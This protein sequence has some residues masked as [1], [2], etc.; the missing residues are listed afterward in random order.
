[1]EPQ[2]PGRMQ[3][4]RERWNLEFHQVAP[5]LHVRITAEARD[6]RTHLD[7]IIEQLHRA[8]Q[9]TEADENSSQQTIASA[10]G[11]KIVA[12]PEIKRMLNQ[13][14]NEVH[15]QLNKLETRERFLN[16]EFATRTDEYRNKKESLL[17]K[18]V[19]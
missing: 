9:H 14:H 2:R 4:D 6:W 11:P 3:I 12:W 19:R 5:K 18:Q 13:I 7:S 8:F 16:N 10:E 15:E 1:M 17:A